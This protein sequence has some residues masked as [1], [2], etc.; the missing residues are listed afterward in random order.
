[1]KQRILLAFLT[2]LLMNLTNAQELTQT[3]KGTVI[4]QASQ[5]PLPGSN[6]IILNTEPFIGGMTNLDGNFRLENVPL[7]RYNIQV[8][9]IGYEPVIIPE[10]MVESGKEVVLN[11]QLKES[12]NQL[13]E[14]TIRANIKKDEAQNSMATISA[15]TFSVEET[16]RYAGG[17]D[18]PARLVTAFAGVSSGLLEDN[19]IV[20]RGNAP[21]GILWRLEGV[22]IPN[23]NHYAGLNTFGGGGVTAFSS[24]MLTN[25]DFLTSAFPAEYGNGLSG[26]FDMKLRTGNNEKYEHA[27]QVG[28]MGIDF[29]S[30]GPFIKGKKASYL[31]NYRYST[32]A[33]LLL[34]LPEN[35][36]VPVYQDLCFKLNFP[37][38]KLGVFSVWAIGALDKYKDSFVKDTA[39][40]EIDDDPELSK[41]HLEM[42]AGGITHKYIINNRAYL[43]TSVTATGNASKWKEEIY[44]F[45]YNAYPSSDIKF[46]S[47]RFSLSSYLNC[48][49]NAKVTTRT[50]F[51]VNNLYYDIAIDASPG[52]PL[53][54][55]DIADADGSTFLLQGYTQSKYYITENLTYNLGM[56]SQFLTLND[57]FTLEPRTGLNWHFSPRQT[58]SIGYGNHSQME[59]LSYYFA[60]IQTAYGPVYPNKDLEFV[61]ANHYVLGYDFSINE[62]VRLKVEPYY[63]QLYNVPVIPDSCYSLINLE[64]D[65]CFNDSLVN[66]GEGRNYGIDITLERFLKDGFYYLFTAS[67]FESKY[68]CGDEIERDSRFNR[69]VVIN[70]LAGKE[71]RVGKEN[72][73]LFG[74]SGRLN[75]MGGD[76]YTPCD[77]AAS[78]DARAVIDDNTRYLGEQNPFSYHFD[79]T[80]MYTFNK[81]NHST[82][83]ALQVKN[84]LGSKEQYG[85][86]YNF[87]KQD[88]IRDEMTIV[89]PVLSYKIEF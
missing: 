79:C 12:L 80:I 88:V 56:H 53:P 60:K 74:I 65:W 29:S 51:V 14:V 9:F 38:Q 8:T 45:D 1:M 83:W 66:R 46:N 89:I 77:R 68:T 5:I 71:W 64:A 13:D 26:V 15:R 73:N 21:K 76:R 47:Y 61:R 78:L 82:K 81:P 7:G 20:V 48:K 63:Q 50:G 54:M 69:N 6:V 58:F 23:P 2:V 16:R 67:I 41:G 49:H 55:I 36:N 75:L 62:N 19:G 44:D 32:F 31:F 42:G 10:V 34:V 4:D 43:N 72:N 59:F 30:E 85:F 25:S 86:V 39:E 11:I 33:L 22:E 17:V 40:W 35:A 27:F 52:L 57:N 87:R 3:V 24:Q 70:A 84:A 28:I 18:D 37:T